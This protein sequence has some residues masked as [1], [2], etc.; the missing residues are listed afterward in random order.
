MPFS[1]PVSNIDFFWYLSVI[2]TY[3]YFLVPDLN[4]LYAIFD[5]WYFLHSQITVLFY[6]SILHYHILLLFRNIFQIQYFFIIFRWFLIFCIK[7]VLKLMKLRSKYN[8]GVSEVYFITHVS[9]LYKELL[10]REDVSN[11]NLIKNFLNL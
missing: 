8:L 4:I 7:Y 5:F 11:I 2:C 10:I 3:V 6:Y 9:V 1:L